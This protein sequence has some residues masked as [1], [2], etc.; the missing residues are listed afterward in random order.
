MSIDLENRSGVDKHEKVHTYLHIIH[1]YIVGTYMGIFH[2]EIVLFCQ[3]TSVRI[4]K[5]RK[6]YRKVFSRRRGSLGI[7]LLYTHLKRL[8]GIDL[9]FGS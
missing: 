5:G 1:T 2:I 8:C 3:T 4:Y 7:L 6:V 9:K